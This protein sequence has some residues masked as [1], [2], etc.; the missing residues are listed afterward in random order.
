VARGAD[1][2]FEFAMPRLDEKIAYQSNAKFHW[3]PY[4]SKFVF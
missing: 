3:D 4:R 2:A 1:S